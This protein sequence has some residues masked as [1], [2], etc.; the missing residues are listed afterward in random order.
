MLEEGHLEEAVQPDLRHPHP[1]AQIPVGLREV[2]RVEALA[3]FDHEHAV[4]LLGQPER[5]DR[6][7]EPGAD[8]DDVLMVHG[9]RVL[10]RGRRPF[11]IAHA[12]AQL[13]EAQR[14]EHQAERQEQDHHQPRRGQRG[15]QRARLVG[16]AQRADV[17]E[18]GDARVD[19]GAGEDDADVGA[20]C[21]PCT[22]PATS[23]LTSPSA[24]ASARVVFSSTDAVGARVRRLA[25]ERLLG[26]QRQV[27]ARGDDAGDLLERALELDAER[28]ARS[29][30]D[31]RRARATACRR[32]RCPTGR[33]ARAAAGRALRAAR[34]RARPRRAARRSCRR[35]PV[36][37]RRPCR[38]RCRPTRAPTATSLAWRSSS[39]MLQLDAAAGQRPA[40]TGKRRETW[41]I[42]SDRF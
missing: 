18:G 12:P 11:E 17:V 7:T 39:A 42:D 35:W 10:A 28:G 19:G 36:C 14:R 8:D 22:A 38:R 33:A 27:H 24:S 5:R 1:A 9:P 23:R 31:P 2:G 20:R 40:P 21:R 16:D 13:A 29:A 6:A 26:R 4:A 30:R 37:P 34:R 41:R 15:G 32:R 3:L 25:D